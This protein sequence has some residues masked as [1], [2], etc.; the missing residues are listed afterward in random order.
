MRILLLVSVL[1]GCS[2]LQA[3]NYLAFDAKKAG[4]E[5]RAALAAAEQNKNMTVKY[6][7]PYG[8][9]VKSNTAAATAMINIELAE[10]TDSLSLELYDS[11]G[12]NVEYLFMGELPAGSHSFQFI[13][14]KA[15]NRPYI[16]V[17]K[18]A[19][20]IESMRVVKFNSF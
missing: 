11:K 12:E 10:A 1:F 4:E 7:K 16:A 5:K 13:P 2:D 20:K 8:V 9:G 6:V 19:D 14:R 3:Q 15:I 18:M 17:F